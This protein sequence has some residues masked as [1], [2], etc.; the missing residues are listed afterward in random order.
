MDEKI[1]YLKKYLKNKELYIFNGTHYQL[2]KDKETIE[3][4]LERLIK[5]DSSYW[6]INC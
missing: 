3:L 5:H 1:E 6:N 2:F 4:L